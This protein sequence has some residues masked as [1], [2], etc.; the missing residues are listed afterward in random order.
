MDTEHHTEKVP[1]SEGRR[2]I[3]QAACPLF[4]EHGYKAVSMQQ[5]ADA[6]HIHKATL[7]HHFLHKEALFTA[8][9][10]VELEQHR[11]ELIHAI[12][13]QTTV[14]D[15]LV[16][17]A[18]QF[19]SRSHT[20][21]GRL[22]TDVRENLSDELRQRLLKEQSF[23]WA[24]LESIFE[25][26][27]RSGELPSVDRELAAS[28]FTGLIWGQIWLRKMERT[29]APLT[30]DLARNLVDILLAGLRTSPAAAPGGM[31]ASESPLL[32]DSHR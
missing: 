32:A 25:E 8:V 15:R 2:R 24:Q 7:Y 22:M 27:T 17:V 14:A 13:Q 19:F 31:A 20:D 1:E 23:P 29:A 11:C 30:E 21:F 28:M 16:S 9:V 5:I 18:W 10:Q 6:A 4:V 12:G 3:L 26:A